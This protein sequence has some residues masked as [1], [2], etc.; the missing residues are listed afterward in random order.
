MNTVSVGPSMDRRQ[1]RIRA[2]AVRRPV[3][4]FCVFAIGLSVSLITALLIAD[5][6]IIPGKA[7]QLL[8]VP[9]TALLIT[10]WISGRAGVRRLRAGELRLAHRHR[11][12]AVG[13]LALPVSH[14]R[15]RRC[16]GHPRSAP[17]D[18]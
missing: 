17:P 3:L 14:G 9:G 1:G 15:D 8:I 2:F 6:S 13:V 16:H 18:G 11:Q 12:V 5:V 10:A 7:A 4:A